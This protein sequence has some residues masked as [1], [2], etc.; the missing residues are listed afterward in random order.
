LIRDV[1][2]LFSAPETFLLF[3][4]RSSISRMLLNSAEDAPDVRLPIS[5]L[6]SVRALDFDPV[7][8]VVYWIE[9]QSNTIRRARDAS[10]RVS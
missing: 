2:C 8:F 9:N 5:D 4:Q 6:K 3:S 7:D 1:Y 10:T